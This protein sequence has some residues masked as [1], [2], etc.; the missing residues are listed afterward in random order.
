M[1]SQD[2][3]SC[4]PSAHLK[5]SSS[6]WKVP[7]TQLHTVLSQLG[8]GKDVALN[9]E[10]SMRELV[11]R[12]L[13]DRDLD[14]ALERRELEAAR[15]AE[16]NARAALWAAR[17]AELAREEVLFRQRRAAFQRLRSIVEAARGEWERRNRAQEAAARQELEVGLKKT[18][19][20]AWVAIGVERD[21]VPSGLKKLAS[22][23]Q[24][25]FRLSDVTDLCRLVS[26]NLADGCDCGRPW[27]VDRDFESHRTRHRCR[28]YG[29]FRC[30]NRR[31][32]KFKQ[33]W[34]SGLAVKGGTQQCRA[35][36]SS[37]EI[38]Q[39]RPLNFER[40]VHV[41]E[42]DAGH[43]DEKRCSE[44]RRRWESG[45]PEVMRWRCDSR[46]LSQRFRERQ[47]RDGF[48]YERG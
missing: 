7:C 13:H 31:C 21:Q 24:R 26:A 40:G 34:S 6:C 35:C 25:C 39:K 2:S 33:P 16:A 30:S 28:Y 19:E 44:C 22:E 18:I 32:K 48:A 3:W 46:A 20:A 12:A 17:A 15:R 5:A 1:L 41:P 37:E 45:R 43:H 29:R 14:L 10:P 42:N 38:W 9:A 4:P 23:L 47:E 8:A 27:R 11:T 36:G